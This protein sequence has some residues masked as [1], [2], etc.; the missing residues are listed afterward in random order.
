MDAAVEAFAT[1]AVFGLLIVEGR[2]T[3]PLVP[4][5]HWISQ[6]AE[7]YAPKMVAGSLPYRSVEERSK[8]AGG[9]L[10]VVTW[11]AVCDRFGIP[12]PP[13][14]DPIQRRSRASP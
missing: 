5:P 4:S 13:Y 8:I 3:D 1:K 14:Q 11:Q 2:E 9:V 7:Q 10:G 12:W 6:C